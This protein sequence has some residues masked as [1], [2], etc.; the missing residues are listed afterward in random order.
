MAL[1]IWV[2]DTLSFSRSSAVMR[3]AVPLIPTSPVF[4]P[5]SPVFIPTSP[6][7]IPTS[8]AFIPTSFDAES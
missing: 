3:F 8:P 7:F 1:A 4:I 2:A 5:T 6:A